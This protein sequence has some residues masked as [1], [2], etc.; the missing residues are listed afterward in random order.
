[1]AVVSRASV[2]F[3]EAI[4]V[5]PVSFVMVLIGCS[6]NAAQC[7]SIATLPVA[8]A[9]MESCRAARSEILSASGDL[10]Y[11]DVRAECRAAVPAAAAK[12]AARTDSTS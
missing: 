6:Q 7:E 1:M 4:L 8:Y 9:T 5:T 3:R 10:G 2:S 11:P 12:R